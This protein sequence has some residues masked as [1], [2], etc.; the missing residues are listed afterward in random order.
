MILDFFYWLSPE[1]GDTWASIFAMFVICA[2]CIFPLMLPVFR[3]SYFIDKMDKKNKKR[4]NK[5]DFDIQFNKLLGESKINA[6]KC[7]EYEK[8]IKE[9]RA[10]IAKLKQE[11]K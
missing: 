10:E 6:D 9:L 3:N 8:A 4:R 1:E 11:R 2:L 5:S 7:E